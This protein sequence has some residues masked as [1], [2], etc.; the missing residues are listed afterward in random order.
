M[1]G[2]SDDWAGGYKMAA[3]GLSQSRHY[4]YACCS[5][6]PADCLQHLNQGTRRMALTSEEATQYLYLF[7]FIL[8]DSYRI[9]DIP[10][11]MDE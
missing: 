2:R 1:K 6:V 10:M 7:L 5:P 4:P 11:N 8:I 9:D 3:N